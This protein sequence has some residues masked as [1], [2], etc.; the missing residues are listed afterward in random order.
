[1]IHPPPREPGTQA[2]PIDLRPY[3]EPFT[4]SPFA[5]YAQLRELSPVQYVIRPDSMPV[6]MVL[7][8]PEAKTA[9]THPAL[10]MDWINAS[11]E[12]R[13]RVMGDPAA[14]RPPQGRSLVTSDAPEHRRLRRSVTQAFTPRRIQLLTP[15][16]EQLTSRLIDRLPL[17]TPFDLVDEFA[18]PLTV[19]VIRLIL[20]VPEFDEERLRGWTTR[21]TTPRSI[22][23][24]SAARRE[25]AQFADRLVAT[26][27]RDPGDDLMSLLIQLSDDETHP[28]DRL[29]D[30]ELT[31][32]VVILLTAGHETTMH[33]VSSA[34]LCLLTH[35]EQLARLRSDTTLIDQ[36]LDEVLRYTPPVAITLPRFA[37]DALDLGGVAIPGDGSEVSIALASAHRDPRCFELPDAFDIGRHSTPLLS[38]GDGAHYCIGAQLARMEA[39]IALLALLERSPGLSL[40]GGPGRFQWRS[41]TTRGPVHLPVIRR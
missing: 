20:G 3:R 41:G 24:A 27:R 36:T 35:P 1:M 8:Y 16:V 2:A 13:A 30:D 12:W 5:F 40:A 25:L 18:G 4:A 32:T 28:Q 26:K 38:F 14:T 39:R 9:L 31:G 15:L 6:W 21:V 7:G 10:R 23:D 19:G 11:P 22:H 29:S 34:V 17:G 33:L 37:A